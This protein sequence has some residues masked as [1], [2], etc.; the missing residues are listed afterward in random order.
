MVEVPYAA[1]LENAAQRWQDADIR[2]L[3]AESALAIG[4]GSPTD[5]GLPKATLADLTGG[6]ATHNADVLLAMLEGKAG[7]FRDVVLFGSAAALIVAGK[8]ADLKTGVAMAGE[9]V[10][11]GRARQTLADLVAISTEET[12]P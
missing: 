4:A 5:A 1:S 7:P 11:N 6:D 10:D 12:A 9:A 2:N 8:A 3:L